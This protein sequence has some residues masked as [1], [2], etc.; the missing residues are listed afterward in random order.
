MFLSLDL[1][2]ARWD[3]LQWWSKSNE[4]CKGLTTWK[5]DGGMSL[6]CDVQQLQFGVTCCFFILSR[7][8]HSNL[9]RR[10]FITKSPLVVFYR[11]EPPRKRRHLEGFPGP[12]ARVLTA[13]PS[14]TRGRPRESNPRRTAAPGGYGRAPPVPAPS[15]APSDGSVASDPLED[16][17][18]VV[19]MDGTHGRVEGQT[20][21]WT[22]TRTR[23]RV[24]GSSRLTRIV[25]ANSDR[26][27][28]LGSRRPWDLDHPDW[29]GS[30]RLTRTCRLT[31]ITPGQL[32]SSWAGSYERGGERRSKTPKPTKWMGQGCST[33]SSAAGL[34]SNPH[35]RHEG[36]GV[37]VPAITNRSL[38]IP[39]PDWQLPW[40]IGA[41][42][43]FRACKGL[44]T[45]ICE[46][47]SD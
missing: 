9:F 1:T 38:V 19:I 39:L 43:P 44:S 23:P 45:G 30:S 3:T 29:L 31:R 26:A 12:T 15:P 36:T 8:F 6:Y 46:R 5:L 7:S 11:L 2:F 33:R 32:R 37:A 10:K 27:G 4:Y 47:S 13:Q 42:R 25:P 18:P 34:N 21:E 14:T 24:L 35:V 20:L 40:Q 41:A 22:W 17:Q 28:W 16:R